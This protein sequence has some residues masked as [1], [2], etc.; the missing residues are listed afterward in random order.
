MGRHG[1]EQNKKKKWNDESHNF[2]VLLETLLNQSDAN[3]DTDAGID[4]YCETEDNYSDAGA[5][6]YCGTELFQDSVLFGSKEKEVPYIDNSP[7]QPYN[8]SKSGDEWIDLCDKLINNLTKINNPTKKNKNDDVDNSVLIESMKIDVTSI[9]NKLQQIQSIGKFFKQRDTMIQSFIKT[10]RKLTPNDN[11]PEIRG[12]YGRKYVECPLALENLFSDN[13]FGNPIGSSLRFFFDDTTVA[14][15]IILMDKMRQTTERV[16]EKRLQFGN[17]RLDKVYKEDLV[18]HSDENDEDLC[19]SYTM[20]MTNINP[21]YTSF[22]CNVS[23]IDEPSMCRISNIDFFNFNSTNILIDLNQKRIITVTNI[24]KEIIN[25]KNSMLRCEREA[26]WKNILT[27]LTYDI[28]YINQGYSYFDIGDNMMIDFVVE[29][30]QQCTITMVQPPYMKIN[31]ICGHGLSIMAIYGLVYIGGSNDTES[32]K[33]PLCRYN[34]IP[35]L[36]KALPD[37]MIDNFRIKYY[38]PED[39]KIENQIGEFIFEDSAKKLDIVAE[40]SK[41]SN[42]YI[43]TIFTLQLDEDEDILEPDMRISHIDLNSSEQTT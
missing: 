26:I 30:E 36:V 10:I 28:K 20:I 24:S 37:E 27:L 11:K 19:T 22:K 23:N 39:F 1:N 31:L 41:D 7:R 16:I 29:K 15:V 42:D 14:E 34:L 43:D 12:D 35:R 9:K 13:V 6:D 3:I 38:E 17:Y 4:D 32:I 21:P 18:V 33:C 8:L 40:N 2:N 5:N 25:L